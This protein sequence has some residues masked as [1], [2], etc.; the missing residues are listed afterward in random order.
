MPEGAPGSKWT[1]EERN[2]LRQNVQM[3]ADWI[4]EQMPWRSVKA[5]RR[6]AEKLGLSWKEPGRLGDLCHECFSGRV[7]KGSYAARF[8]ICPTCYQKERERR[9]RQMRD[10]KEAKARAEAARQAYYRAGRD[11]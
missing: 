3:G 4:H 7:V 6:K 1:L 9:F 8:G 5:I 11:A 10:E 2:F